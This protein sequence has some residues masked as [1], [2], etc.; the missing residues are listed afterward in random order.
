MPDLPVVQDYFW[1]R[2]QVLKL[3]QLQQK[4][5]RQRLKSCIFCAFHCMSGTKKSIESLYI[6]LLGHAHEQTSQFSAKL[7]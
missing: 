4:E 7:F 3:Q 6:L 2:V 1:Q 5:R